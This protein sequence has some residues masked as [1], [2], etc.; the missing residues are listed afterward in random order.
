[1]KIKEK[2][3]KTNENPGKIMTKHWTP[4]K[5]KETWVNDTKNQRN[6][7]TTNENQR[8]KHENQRNTLE[9]TMKTNEQKQW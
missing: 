6:R 3:I 1:M 9:K 7:W 8:T 5:T 2:L 4:T